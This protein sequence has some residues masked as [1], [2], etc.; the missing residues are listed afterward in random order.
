MI[1]AADRQG[2]AEHSS[3]GGGVLEGF[4]LCTCIGG[5]VLWSLYSRCPQKAPFLTPPPTPKFAL[6]PAGKEDAGEPEPT[7]NPPPVTK[8]QATLS[9]AGMPALTGWLAT[10]RRPIDA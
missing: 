5:F 2:P 6:A 4:A 1:E 7:M 8:S 10:T 3:P 9:P